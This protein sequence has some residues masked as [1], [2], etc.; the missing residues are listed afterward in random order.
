MRFHVTQKFA[1][2]RPGTTQAVEI[3][4][5][6]RL[7]GHQCKTDELEPNG[8]LMAP[9]QIALSTALGRS[10]QSIDETR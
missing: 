9:T 2:P 8:M 5:T 6:C 10:T 1:L 3:G 4:C 7:I